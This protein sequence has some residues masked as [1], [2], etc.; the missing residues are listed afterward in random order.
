MEENLYT[1]GAAAVL[2]SV[3]LVVYNRDLDY[4]PSLAVQ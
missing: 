3:D 4:G 2:L 1:A